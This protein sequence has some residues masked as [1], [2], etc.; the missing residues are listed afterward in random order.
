MRNAGLD[1]A[2]AGIKVARRNI[3]LRYADDTTLMAESEEE[4]K[5]L[6]MRVKEESEKSGLKLNI[7]WESGPG[8]GAESPSLWDMGHDWKGSH[9]L[10]HPTLHVPG[11]PGAKPLVEDLLLGLGFIC[12][13]AAPLLRSIE[14]ETLTQGFVKRKKTNNIQKT[15]IMASGPITSWQ[16]SSVQLLSHVWLFVTP[17]TAAHQTSLSITNSRNLLKLIFIELV[18]PSNHFILCHPLLLP[19]SIFPS[20]RVFSNE[21]G[22]CIRCPN[23][24]SFRFRIGPSDKYSGLISFRMDDWIS[25]QSKGLSRVLSIT[26]VQKHQFFGTRFSL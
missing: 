2:Q 23:Y 1:E 14:S 7:H 17:W 3:N 26:T 5:R 11:E 16:I 15:K 21:S 12:S 6:F 8:S 18:M 19:P 22:L 25:L 13:R 9:P 24:W 4:W 10:T 20:I